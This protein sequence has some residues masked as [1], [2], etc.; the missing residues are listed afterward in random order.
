MFSIQEIIQSSIEQGKKVLI[1]VVTKS[2]TTL[3]TV[4]NFAVLLDCLKGYFPQTYMQYI[5]ATTDKY[6]L[7]WQMAQHEG[8]D[9]L[10]IPTDLGGRF[11]VFSAVG[12]FPLY[13]LDINIDELL[14]GAQKMFV[15]CTNSIQTNCAA[16]SAALLF[17][18]YKKGKSIHDTFLFSVELEYVGKWYRQLMAESLG[19][20]HDL[21]KQKVNKGMTPTVSIGSID[22]HSMAQ[23]YLGGPHDKIT[24]FISIKKTRRTISIKDV[25]CLGD[26]F[27]WLRNKTFLD[28]MEAIVEGTKRAYFR[29]GQPFCSITLPEKNE[30]YIGQLLQMKM[31][32]VIFLAHF[33]HVNPFDQPNVELYKKETEAIFKESL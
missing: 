1:N 5:V 20:E 11:S 4:A 2:G 24:T 6:S 29:T 3:E 8:F 19:K 25:Q 23:L 9:C 33:L 12:M 22:L 16:Q 7:L 21:H 30:F 27:Q 31:F 32:E 26:R 15:A 17:M 10:E 14:R 28:L 13:F 18:H